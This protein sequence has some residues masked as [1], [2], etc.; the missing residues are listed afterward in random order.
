M[1]APHQTALSDSLVG[2][3]PTPPLSSPVIQAGENL[4]RILRSV[5]GRSLRPLKHDRELP[6]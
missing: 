6:D 3:M 4:A 1:R 5:T 2:A